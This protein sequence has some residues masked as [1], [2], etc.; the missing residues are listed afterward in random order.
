MHK[1]KYNL[2]NEYFLFGV[3]REKQIKNMY[4]KLLSMFYSNIIIIILSFY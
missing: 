4:P 3:L 1:K 2:Y